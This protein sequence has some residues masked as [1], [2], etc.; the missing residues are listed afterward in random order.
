MPSSAASDFVPAF[1]VR[2]LCF[3]ASPPPN[4]STAE[5]SLNIRA[6]FVVASSDPRALARGSTG[7]V[8]GAGL[9][10][11]RIRSAADD[12]LLLGIDD[13]PVR[14]ADVFDTTRR[15]LEG[16]VLSIVR[17]C[18]GLLMFNVAFP[19]RSAFV[20]TS[21]QSLGIAGCDSRRRRKQYLVNKLR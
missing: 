7:V 6:V 11:G 20:A 16:A 2:K 14:S 9:D 12:Y 15:E 8:T 17:V 5:E 19:L 3:L 4:P 13:G 21:K 18:K 1:L 10:L